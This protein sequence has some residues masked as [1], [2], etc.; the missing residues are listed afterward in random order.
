MSF[1]HLKLIEPLIAQLS[2]LDY[3]KPT[4]I[5]REVI[6]KVLE[7]HDVMAAAETGSGKT[8]A[9]VLPILQQ[10]SSQ[11]PAESNKTLCLILTPTRELAIQVQESI[12][13]YGAQ[14]VL[15]SEVV[16]GGVKINPQMKRLRGGV[17]LLVATPGRLL[18]LVEKNAIQLDRVQSFV[19]DEADRM[20]D[21]GFKNDLVHIFELIPHRR[22]TLFFS[23]TFSPAVEAIAKAILRSPV[24]VKT[25][26]P[27]QGGKNIRQW[28]HPVDKKRKG[29]LLNFVLSE[30]KA[31]KVLVFTKTKKGANKVSYD[32]EKSGIAS[33]TI[34]GDRSQQQRIRA[35]NDFKSGK[36][37]VLVATDVA[38]RGLD[39]DQLPLVVN[40]D[41]PKVAEDYVH[42]IGRTGRAGETGTAVSL[43]SADEFDYLMNIENLTRQLIARKNL[44]QF[45]PEHRL[46]ESRLGNVKK[47][48]P[49]KKKLAKQKEKMAQGGIKK[50]SKTG[51]TAPSF[52]V[53]KKKKS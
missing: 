45:E 53:R 24:I 35:L 23:A 43:V 4:A 3:Q 47:K 34:H 15:R 25:N 12:M 44:A 10:L 21:L 40:F 52:T 22:Q 19:L 36:V 41:L 28:L 26:K 5:Q 32:L 31:E 51:R 29:E 14:L 39:I 17:E 6:P 46:P 27:N 16:F 1:Q 50:S 18:D 2:Q 30:H 38:A 49:H 13:Q 7:G 8:A 9:F 33:A 42:R 37:R 20:L 48:K 11:P